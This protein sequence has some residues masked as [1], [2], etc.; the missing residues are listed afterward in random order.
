[1]IVEEIKELRTLIDEW[2]DVMPPQNKTKIMSDYYLEC[3]EK[4]NKILGLAMSLSL[5]G[6]ET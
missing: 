3:N 5:T 4:T 6:K 1:M 2:Y